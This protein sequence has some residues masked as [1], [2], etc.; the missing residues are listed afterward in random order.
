MHDTLKK[1]FQRND[2]L[3]WSTVAACVL[4]IANA[5]MNISASGH[6][7]FFVNL[8]Y[9]LCLIMLCYA[10]LRQAIA[11]FMFMASSISLMGQ[12]ARYISL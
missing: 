10:E 3:L 7:S 12:A 6:R 8:M 4:W 2:V 9:I 5:A 11:F 1:G